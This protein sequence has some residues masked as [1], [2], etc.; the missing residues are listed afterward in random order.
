M[1][2]LVERWRLLNIC[3]SS[4]VR[5]P[6][7][8]HV[9]DEVF[10]ISRIIKVEV[11]VRLR[12]I[13]LTETLIILDIS[14]TESNNCFIIHWTDPFFLASFCQVLSVF[15]LFHVIS[16]QL[17]CHLCRPFYVCESLSST[18]F[19]MS[20]SV[21]EANLEVMFLRPF[22]RQA[23]QSARILTWLPLEIMHRGHTWHDYPWPWVSLTWLL[24]NLQLDDV[25]SAD[26]ESSLY[27]FGQSEKR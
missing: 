22:W 10:V 12:L 14:K 23:T 2:A 8:K 25:P 19:S 13:T 6:N 16:K 1:R 18:T 5:R 9:L 17:L 15:F 20:Y 4:A 21:N 3:R 26:F 24:H 11:G 27:A 7:F